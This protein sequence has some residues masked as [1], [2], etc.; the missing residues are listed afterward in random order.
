MKKTMILM[1]LVAV[2]SVGCSS[3]TGDATSTTTIES[4][5]STQSTTHSTT[6][7][8]TETTTAAQGN[9]PVVTL[10][11]NDIRY[12]PLLNS[13][14]G[15]YGIAE[16][17]ALDNDAITYPYTT[18]QFFNPANG[19]TIVSEYQNPA[20]LYRVI[21]QLGNWVEPNN[22]YLMIRAISQEL[23]LGQTV[24]GNWLVFDTTG[25]I[26]GDLGND[27]RVEYVQPLDTLYVSGAPYGIDF[28]NKL[29]HKIE[30]TQSFQQSVVNRL[31]EQY[32]FTIGNTPNTYTFTRGD[33]VYAFTSYRFD[34][35]Y[36]LASYDGEDDFNGLESR[37]A[38]IG[39]GGEMLIEPHYYIAPISGDYFAVASDILNDLPEI[40]L[41]IK[42]YD[43]NAFKK[44]IYQDDNRLTDEL[45]FKITHVADTLFY[46]YDGNQF[47]FIDVASNLTVWQD[48]A[49]DANYQFA[50]V[51]ESVV[52]VDALDSPQVMHIISDGKIVKS[53]YQTYPTA[54]GAVAKHMHQQGNSSIEIPVVALSDDAVSDKINRHFEV[55][56][57]TEAYTDNYFAESH[58]SSFTVEYHKKLVQIIF[59]DE[60]YGFGAAHPNSAIS[61]YVFSAK[62]GQAYAFTDWFKKDS[63][64]QLALAKIMR[65]DDSIEQTFDYDASLSDAEVAEMLHLEQVE[66]YFTKDRLIIVYNPYDISPYAAGHLYF[67]LDLD[68][69]KGYLSADAQ[70]LLF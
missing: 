10:T 6:Q 19:Q 64:Y 45:Y 23:Y 2:L 26:Y 46:V 21:D 63:G 55:N 41:N 67:E 69:I 68:D 47:Q 24:K 62:T 65:A 56:E 1:A 37:M 39:A 38:L 28:N 14:I 20:T 43:Q 66:Y 54:D 52:A 16:I 61:C 36:L 50:Q 9:T 7:M 18:A 34:G 17:T 12:L 51:G 30:N 60:W 70:A 3:N 35:D 57:Q 8:T 29:I 53:L 5:S 22:D 33:D 32:N 4:D 27:G 58:S 59:G 15:G 44:A 48:V 11:P 25:H 40:S 13:E 31:T 49:L 42:N